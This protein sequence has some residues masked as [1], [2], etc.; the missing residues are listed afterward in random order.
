MDV[1]PTIINY[2]NYAGLATEFNTGAYHKDLDG[3]LYFGGLEGFYWFKPEE[4][5]EN[6]F[7]PKTD[8]TGF[9][10]S[11]EIQSMNDNVRLYHDQN[12]VSFSFSSLQYS[13]PEKNQYQYRLKNYDDEWI[14]S[15]N[16]NSARYSFLPPGEYEFQ[17]KS[18]NYDGV[19]NPKP[20]SFAF[21]IAPPWYF[22]VL[23]K[24]IYTLLFLA[25]I[26]GIYSYL[27]WRWRMK[28]D[29]QLKEEEAQRLKRLNDFKSK[30]YT[31]ISHEFRTPLTLISGPVDAKL[32]EGRLSDSDFANFSMIK[33]NTTRLMGLVD[34]LLHMA[35]LE[36]GKLKLKVEQGNLGLFLRA[37]A[38]SFEYRAEI[39]NMEFSFRTDTLEGIW[40]DEDA[41]EKIVTNLLSNAFKYS[42]ENGTCEFNATDRGDGMVRISVKN[43]V[44]DFPDMQLDKLFNRFYQQDEYAEG[45]GVG[46]SLVK[47]LVEL[48]QG[49][50]SVQMEDENIIHFMVTL[51]VKKE[52]FDDEAITKDDTDQRQPIVSAIS[53]TIDIQADAEQNESVEE[54]PIVLI[55]EDHKEVREFLVSVWKN[56]Y[57]I[58]QA[59]NGKEGM[60][61]ALRI[62]PDLIVTDV[63]MPVFSGIEL[64]NTLKTDER[65]SHIPIIL[66][67]AGM[68]EEDELKGLQSGADDFITKPFKLRI[69]EKRVE[70]LIETR[71]ALR[72]RYSQEVTL[73]AKDI[74]LT[75]TDEIFLNRMQKVLDEHLS[76]ADFNAAIFCKEVGMSRMQLHRKLLAFTGL[77]TTGFIR[78]QRL[79]QA[80]H[81]LETSD[82]TINE[83]AYTVGFNTPS[84]FIKCFKEAYDKTPTEYL[85]SKQT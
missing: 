41:M 72:S 16:N 3:N 79:K 60:N 44:D 20:A 53:N 83:V 9:M 13:L 82:A 70:N 17:V 71:K 40:Y 47:E 75:P 64:C 26:F 24:I 2:N 45:A 81:I 80:V 28:L 74:A 30:L 58:F 35:K 37:L 54:L 29:L 67:T 11:N 4:I 57:Q 73:K 7:L 52:L 25:I 69:L 43:S 5:Q 14:S 85:Q 77:S 63:R 19:W 42:P 8:I 62:V 48:Y 18:S 65:T 59:Q 84:Y 22:T 32:G 15:G 61:K 6:R 49:E 56:K 1:A 10:V 76:D 55:V 36:K 33:R 39:K 21:V 46:L 66:L 12:T 31:D 50:V 68:G 38:S 34:Q 27:K 51:P 78:S 23:A